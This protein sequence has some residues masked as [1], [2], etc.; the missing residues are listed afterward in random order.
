[1]KEYPKDAEVFAVFCENGR[2]PTKMHESYA[3]ATEE[4]QQ[5]AK[6][7]PGLK[8]FIMAPVRYAFGTVNVEVD[9]V[10]EEGEQ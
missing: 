4:A 8:F 9:S 1:M 2:P 10:W 3:E 7:Q 5:L 6:K